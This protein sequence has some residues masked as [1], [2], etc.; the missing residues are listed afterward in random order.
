MPVELS[1]SRVL[2]TGATG[3]IGHAIARALHARGAHLI[4]TGRKTDVLD[5]L[6]AQLGDRVEAKPPDLADALAVHRFGEEVGEVDVFVANAG[7]PGTGKLDEYTSEQIDRVLDV[8]LRSPI[9]MTRALLPGM[10][11]RARGHLVYI[12]SMSGK[13]PTV[14]SSLYNGTKFGLRGFAHAM[15]QD[16]QGSGVGVTTVFPGF[17]SDAG[18]WADGGLDLPRGVRTRTPEQVAD[19]VVTGIEKN[20]AEIDVAPLF[21]RLGGWLSGPAPNLIAAI[22]RRGGGNDIADQ[23]AERQV[24]KR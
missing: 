10:V 19:A 13:V 5:E 11:E 14:R 15:H 12:S 21:V 2:L 6:V 8:N 18:M 3:G 22:N 20:R 16:L 23:L 1:G 24:E 7:M 4:L 9:Q 17:I